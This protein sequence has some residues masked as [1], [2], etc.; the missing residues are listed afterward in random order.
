[1]PT[2]IR[3]AWPADAVVVSAIL[4][5]AAAW[6]DMRDETLWRA[7]ELETPA[8]AADVDTGLF[9]IADVDEVPSGV[10]RLQRSDPDFWP[11]VP[12]G[13]SLF[14]H[15]LAVRRS[16]A[17]S[18]VSTAL[19]RFAVERTRELGLESLR[20]DC[21]AARPKLR[22]IYERFGFFHHSDRQVGPYFVSR[23]VYNVKGRETAGRSAVRGDTGAG[24][25]AVTARDH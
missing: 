5:E 12:D 9:W 6:L 10:V 16:A 8:I 2:V 7:D 15:R 14:L 13:T 19:L 22:A 25:S 4:R 18:G 24:N 3:P 11:E 23:Y 17:A 1:M 20:L 21:E